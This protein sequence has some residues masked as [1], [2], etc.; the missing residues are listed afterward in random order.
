MVFRFPVAVVLATLAACAGGGGGTETLPDCDARAVLTDADF[1]G[2]LVLAA[3]TCWSVEQSLRLSDGTVTV[4]EGVSIHFATTTSIDVGSG[5][6]LRLAGTEAAPIELGTS[7]PAIAWTG[8]RLQDSQGTANQWD[9]V[10]IDNAGGD[11]WNGADYSDA[12]VFVAGTSTLAMDHVF[13][14]D[15]RGHGLILNQPDVDVSFTN[16]AFERNDTPAYVHP[17]VAHAI[18]AETRFEGNTN[19]WVRVVFSNNDTVESSRTWAAI[20]VPWR[21]EDRFFVG[22][23]LTLAPGATV[24]MAQGASLW[25]E[26][27]CGAPRG[28]N[29]GRSRGHPGG[30]RPRGLLAGDPDRGPRPLRGCGDSPMRGASSGTATRTPPPRSS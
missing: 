10:R 16:G 28:G 4:E 29:R 15:S 21:V 11:N 18:G 27:Q 30:R 20:G 2:G 9:H 24:E 3:G 14:R 1:V 6:T 7:D 8:V 23:E 19:P 25:G 5:G 26:P 12:A 17:E 13:I 22:D